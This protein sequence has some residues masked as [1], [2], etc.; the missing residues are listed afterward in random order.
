M[1]EL[2]STEE[3]SPLKK[4]EKGQTHDDSWDGRGSHMTTKSHMLCHVKLA[5]TKDL[6]AY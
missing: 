6:N 1:K 3:L 4:S 2:A 5:I